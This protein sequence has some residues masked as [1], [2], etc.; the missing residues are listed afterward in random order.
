M[1]KMNPQ[2]IAFILF[3]GLNLGSAYGRDVVCKIEKNAPTI[4]GIRELKYH[5]SDVPGT[6]GSIDITRDE[7][8]QT[9]VRSLMQTGVQALMGE[10]LT[11]GD[12][13]DIPSGSAYSVTESVRVRKSKNESGESSFALIKLR[14]T[15]SGQHCDGA[16]MCT[17]TSEI[18]KSEAIACKDSNDEIKPVQ[19]QGGGHYDPCAGEGPNC[20]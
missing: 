6:F 8:T 5:H 3:A 17:L 4:G 9:G 14:E 7:R 2:S 20:E 11:W 1:L 13:K 15:I 19:P 10:D 12:T 18:I 16:H